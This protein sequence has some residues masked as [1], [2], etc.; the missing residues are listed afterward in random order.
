VSGDEARLRQVVANLLD[1]ARTHTPP[2]TPVS[3]RLST[4]G[5]TA[6]IEVAD[7]GPGIAPHEAERIFERFYRGDPSRSRA[8]GGTGLGLA[9]AA[10]IAE[11]HGGALSMSSRPDEGATFVVTLPLRGDD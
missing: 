11:A 7:R 2:G 5:E 1:N 4:S 10:A 9:I 3:V 6:S 8:S